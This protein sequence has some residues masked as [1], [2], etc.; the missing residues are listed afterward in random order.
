MSQFV[1][2]D[3]PKSES[4]FYVRALYLLAQ[5]LYNTDARLFG[6][7]SKLPESKEH[8]RSHIP[9][10]RLRSQHDWV[11]DRNLDTIIT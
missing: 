3:S 2:F 10:S 1:L 6:E 7:F 8:V 4:P 5:A 9:K 11:T